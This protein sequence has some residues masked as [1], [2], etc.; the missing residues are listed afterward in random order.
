MGLSARLRLRIW[1]LGYQ[2]EEWQRQA[3]RRELVG[4][5]LRRLLLPALKLVRWRRGKR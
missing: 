4:E 1:L 2:L 5:A 3:E